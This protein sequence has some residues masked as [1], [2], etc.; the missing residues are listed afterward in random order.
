MTDDKKI[1]CNS[2]TNINC[3][4]CDGN[5]CNTEIERIGNNCYKCTGATCL[6]PNVPSVTCLKDSEGKSDCYTEING[7]YK[8]IF[9]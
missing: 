1:V 6:Q 4:K 5:D 7:N 3:I 2:L 8:T 9:A